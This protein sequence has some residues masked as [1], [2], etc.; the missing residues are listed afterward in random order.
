MFINPFNEPLNEIFPSKIKGAHIFFMFNG[1]WLTKLS[2]DWFFASIF[3]S[4]KLPLITVPFMLKITL[5]IFINELF[6]AIIPLVIL[7]VQSKFIF[8]W[9]NSKELSVE[10]SLTKIISSIK[11]KLHFF[12]SLKKFSISPYS[13]KTGIIKLIFG[14]TSDL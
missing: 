14:F 3:R 5:S 11:S 8:F 10:Q 2:I 12:N 4:S 6:I 7:V 9:S 1:R 13:L